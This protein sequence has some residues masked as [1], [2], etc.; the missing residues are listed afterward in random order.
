MVHSAKQQYFS[1]L[2]TLLSHDSRKLWSFQYLSS[3]Q[4]AQTTIIDAS[5]DAMNQYFLTIVQKTVADW[6]SSSVSPL[7]YINCVDVPDLSISEVQFDDVVGYIQVLGVHKAVG[8]DG[9]STHFIK[10]S[11]YG[12]TVVLI[13]HLDLLSHKQSSF[14]LG[15]LPRMFCYMLM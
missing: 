1:H 5:C 15:I 14:V 9:I 7:S 6:P 8:I 12:M 4:K 2:A 3:H 11:P 13:S 10:A